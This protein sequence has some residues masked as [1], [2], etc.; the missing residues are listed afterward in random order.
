METIDLTDGFDLKRIAESWGNL[1]DEH[2]RHFD[3]FVRRSLRNPVAV[4]ERAPSEIVYRRLL[5][6]YALSDEI[7]SERSRGSVSS[8]APAKLKGPE[9][10]RKRSRATVNR[11]SENGKT[12]FLCFSRPLVGRAGGCAFAAVIRS[13]PKGTSDTGHHYN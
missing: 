12:S 13:Y 11:F 3:P 8:V 4:F 6:S 7:G 9:K 10:G 5:S 1:S 2:S